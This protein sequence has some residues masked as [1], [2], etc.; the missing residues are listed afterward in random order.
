GRIDSAQSYDAR[1]SVIRRHRPVRPRPSHGAHPRAGPVLEL[2]RDVPR[3]ERFRMPD[4]V[5]PSFADLGLPRALVGA[6]ERRGVRTPFPIQAATIPDA[7][8]GRDVL[9]RGE[10]GSGKTLAFG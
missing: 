6:L 9:G 4:P 5:T 2:S 1:G 10:T 3:L 8:A 7:L